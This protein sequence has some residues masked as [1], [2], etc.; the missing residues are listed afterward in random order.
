[1]HATYKWFT[2]GTIRETTYGSHAWSGES[3][4][5]ATL[6]PGGPIMGINSMTV[7]SE[8]GQSRSYDTPCNNHFTFQSIYL[9]YLQM[10]SSCYAAIRTTAQQSWCVGETELVA[11]SSDIQQ[12]L[13]FHAFLIY[14]L[15]LYYLTY[16][17]A[18]NFWGLKIFMVKI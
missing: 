8:Y 16:N 12:S 6:G 14:I 7:I 11:A 17:K 18:R 5:A 3:S 4:V 13:S 9:Y 10:S 2:R 15:K 1:M